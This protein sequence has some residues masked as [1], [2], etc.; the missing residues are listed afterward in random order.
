MAILNIKIYHIL[1][2][3]N[4]N[5]KQKNRLFLIIQINKI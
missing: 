3:A 5:F 2:L 1:F 4:N